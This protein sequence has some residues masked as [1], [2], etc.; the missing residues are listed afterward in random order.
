MIAETQ[1]PTNQREPKVIPI[2][3]QCLL[4][5]KRLLIQSAVSTLCHC[6]PETAL[7]LTTTGVPE[8]HQTEIHML[9]H[10]RDSEKETPFIL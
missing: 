1:M 3:T 4:K 9:F 5:L 8:V 6:K 2:T 10:L 7:D